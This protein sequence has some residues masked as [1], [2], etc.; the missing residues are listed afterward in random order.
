MWEVLFMV[1]AWL[2]ITPPPQYFTDT[3]NVVLIEFSENM[4][5]EGLLD[6]NN[7]SIVDENNKSWII[8]R[9]GIVSELDG[10]IIS[11]TSLVAL[12]SERLAYRGE[13]TI[14]AVNVKDKA[15][16]VIEGNNSAWYFYNGFVPNRFETTPVNIG[17]EN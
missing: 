5:I 2:T 11:D 7:Y 14:T 12:V 16:N 9:V 15:G 4:S 13:Y 17:K 3:T 10:I 1:G 6:V 8:Y